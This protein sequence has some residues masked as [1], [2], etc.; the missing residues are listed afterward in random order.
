VEQIVNNPERD[1]ASMVAIAENAIRGLAR[2]AS[3]ERPQPDEVRESI[4]HAIA[5]LDEVHD[6]AE[7]GDAIESAM[8][9]CHATLSTLLDRLGGG[10]P[11]R[12][13]GIVCI[14]GDC[15]RHSWEGT[16]YCGE[17][18]G[19]PEYVTDPG[20]PEN[21]NGKIIVLPPDPVKDAAAL[22]ERWLYVG[23]MTRP[24]IDALEQQ[25]EEWIRS[26]SVPQSEREG[27]RAALI[28]LDEPMQ[29]IRDHDPKVLVE[30]PSALFRRFD[31]AR[32]AL[33]EEPS[34]DN[35]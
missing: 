32:A 4:E 30:M 22:L 34:D 35:D 13:S 21:P 18:G 29:W 31:R 12:C 3:Q 8:L 14:E 25:T 10:G 9:E 24:D 6:L 19:L 17:H 20:H 28:G 26:R 5:A 11:P 7:Q 15:K 2:A 27:L 23:S 16:L 1:A 33:A